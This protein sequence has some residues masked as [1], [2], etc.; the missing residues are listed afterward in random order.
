MDRKEL[1]P[2]L[3]SVRFSTEDINSAVEMTVSYYNSVPPF[4]DYQTSNSFPWTWLLL[5]GV[6][7]HLLK[8]ASINEA[9]NELN[10]EA[11]GVSIQ[12][13]NKASIFS[14]IGGQ[15][16]EEFK[17]KVLDIKMS[18]NIGSCFSSSPSELAYLAR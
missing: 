16:W 18:I 6:S 8:S 13:K 2:L 3:R 15:L 1:N 7:G 12:D 17:A 10:Y 14:Q 9:S 5:T 4:V 11:S